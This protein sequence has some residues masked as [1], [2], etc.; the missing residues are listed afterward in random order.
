MREL[1]RRGIAIS[2]PG[3]NDWSHEADIKSGM[4]GYVHLTLMRGHPMEK[5]VVDEGR[6][7]KL[8]YIR[9]DPSVVK[10][11]G[12]VGTLGVSNKSGIAPIPLLDFL[13]QLDREV[14]YTRT[15]W[16]DPAIQARLQPAQKCE[17]LVPTTV[18]LAFLTIP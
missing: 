10:L 8:V 4:D 16:K 6:I 2:A 12:V 13:D 11:D 5:T 15:K 7:K 1:R 14:L 18:P 17:L 3:G 9:I